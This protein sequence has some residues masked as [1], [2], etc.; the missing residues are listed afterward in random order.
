MT[1]A[2]DQPDYLQPYV[3]AVSRHGA[4][5]RSLLWASPKTQAA[6]FDALV[7]ACEL[8][9]KS[10]L[11]VG[12]GRADLLDYLY[13]SDIRPDHYVGIEAVAALADEAERR[14]RPRSMIVRADFVSEPARMFVGADVVIFCGSLNTLPPD[15]FYR[16]LRTA[17]EATAS[18][19]VFN[20]LCS[21]QLAGADYLH[22]YDEDAVVRFV[23]GF[24]PGVEVSRVDDYLPGDCTLCVRKPE[25][26]K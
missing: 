26:G 9:G 16:T 13:A 7:R 2:A 3:N 14:M 24:A 22:W 23:S 10:I 6:R 12:C 15:A 11:D 17:Y 5:F 19:L 21:Q 8:D 1:G 20:F 18:E 4:G 25:D